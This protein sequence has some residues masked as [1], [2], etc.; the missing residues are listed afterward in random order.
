MFG[1]NDSLTIMGSVN[2]PLSN[3][4]CSDEEIYKFKPF[5]LKQHKPK[6]PE[7]LNPKGRSGHRIVSDDTYLYSFGGFNPNL[8]D[9]DSA[10]NDNMKLFKEIWRFNFATNEWYKMAKFEKTM[11]RELASNALL[12]SGNMLIVHG[13]TGVPFG[14][15]CC[16]KTYLCNLKRDKKL[17]LLKTTGSIPPPQYGQSMVIDKHKLYVV[18]GTSG[19]EYSSDVHC[20]D[21]VTNVWESVYI[22]KGRNTLEP[23]GRYRHEVAFYNSK[24]IVFGGGTVDKAFGF[25]VSIFFPPHK[26]KTLL[27]F[28]V[29]RN[30]QPLI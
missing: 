28:F 22:T 18:G 5:V 24:I 20:L 7:E 11:P 26:N 23:E 1:E 27:I 21:L 30:Y 12:L 3:E 2:K 8:D 4:S 19:F 9:D 17:T 10:D 16:N 29:Y 14:L 25:K 6:T 15:T 13:G